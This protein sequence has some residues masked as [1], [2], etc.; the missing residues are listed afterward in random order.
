M[1]N[2]LSIALLAT[3]QAAIVEDGLWTGHD[4]LDPTTKIGVTNGVPYSTNDLQQR[5]I[6]SPMPIDGDPEDI[7]GGWEN[8]Q[9]VKNI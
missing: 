2:K 6:T 3:V 7:S 8:A 1:I 5:R 9:N 4:F